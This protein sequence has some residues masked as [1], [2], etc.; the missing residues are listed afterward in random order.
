MT[1]TG[2]SP[3]RAARTACPTC[4]TACSRSANGRWK[5]VANLSAF[6]KSHPVANPDEDD[7]E[8][9][10]PGTAWRAPRRALP[11]GL[12]PR[13]A[14]PGD[15]ARRDPRV[16]DMSAKLGHIV[17]TALHRAAAAAMAPNP[18]R[19]P[20]RVRAARRHGPERARVAADR[21][22]A[23]QGAG[24][25][26][27]AGGRPRRPARPALRARAERNTGGP[28]ARHGRDRPHRGPR[29]AAPRQSSPG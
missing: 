2:C 15:A 28:D 13:R 4:Q 25:A 23:A 10:G 24:L 19:Q 3:E 18:D 26:P 11:D 12:E 5:L 6:Q 17:P 14:R 8:P 1:S 22:P 20:G 16:V 9:D 29:H 27:R 21:E 7:F